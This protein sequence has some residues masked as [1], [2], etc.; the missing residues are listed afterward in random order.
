M[1]RAIAALESQRPV[2]GDTVTELA[3]APLRQ[4]LAQAESTVAPSQ[5]RRAQVTVLFAD[6]VD[7]TA[8]AG[9]LDAEDVLQ[10]F[11]RMLESAAACVRTRGGRV[12]RYTGDGLKAGFGTAG[13][14]EDDAA[15]AVQAGL[16]I[17][18]AAQEHAAW[19]A[20]AHGLQGFAVRVGAHT[21]EV[22]L[23]AGFE[24]DN[25]LTGDTVNL[26]ARMEQAAPPGGLRISAETWAHVRGR[27]DADAQPPLA[28]KGLDQPMS[29]W[30]VRGARGGEVE[31]GIAG[32]A[33]PMIG[34][35]A[36]HARLLDAL[37]AAAAGGGLQA[38]TVV[39]DAGIG[40]TRL[41]REALAEA[42]AGGA[43]VLLARAQPGAEMRPW[44]MLHGLLSAHCGI[45]DSDGAKAARG[46]LLAGLA[47]ELGDDA[48][49]K[50][51]R[52]GQL[53]G[54]DFGDVPA[55]RG[56]DAR[57]LRDL[58]FAALLEWLAGLCRSR[59][60]TA[61]VLV[62]EDLHWADEASLDALAH[63]MEQASALPLLLLAS[64]R[65]RLLERRPG[66]GTG[67]L[68]ALLAL[69]P[70]PEADRSLLA[71][72]LLQRIAHP[73]ERLRALLVQRA[74]GN[75]Y[76]MEELL[77]RLLDDGVIGR[78]GAQWRVDE[79]RLERLR[80]PTTLVGLLQA[81]LDALPAP[82]RH[83][84][85]RASI[86]GHVFWD[87]ALAQIDAAAPQTLDALQ[88]RQWVRERAA[89]AFEGTAERQFDHHLLHQVT[90]DTVLKDER[91]RGH[92]A[93]ARWLAERTAGRAPEFLAITG[94]HAE[95]AGDL[96]LAVDCY[97]R[98]ADEAA[99][100]FANA[101]AID[102]LRK[103]LRLLPADA[104][105]RR[106][107]LLGTLYELGDR[108]GDRPLQHEALALREALLS[109]HPDPVRQATW[110]ADRALLADREG[111]PD[112]AFALATE[113][114]ALAGA[115]GNDDAAA[116]AHGE[117]CWLHGQRLELDDA[118]RHLAAA[119]AA[120]ARVRD[121]H[122]Q[123][124]VSVRVLAGVVE[125]LNN[126]Y[127][128]AR[129]MLEPVLERAEAAQLPRAQLGALNYL[130]SVSTGLQEHARAVQEAAR[131]IALARRLGNVAQTGAALYMQATA[132]N[133]MGE[134]AQALAAAHEAL[135]LLRQ[136]RSRLMEADALNVVGHAHAGRGDP[137]AARAA[138]GQA[139]QV[140]EDMTPGG[141][142]GLSR[143][144]LIA[145]QDL[146][147]GDLPAALA[148][149][150]T[151]LAGLAAGATID[152]INDQTAVHWACQRVLAA[153]GD[154]RAPDHLRGLQAALRAQ[155]LQRTGSEAQAQALIAGTALY[156][157]I[158]A[159]E[160][161]APPGSEPARATA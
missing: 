23:G 5:L 44:G 67:G 28:V 34:R 17:L 56:L 54:L 118:R 125:I 19:A 20:Q 69:T 55:L 79:Q 117:L 15:Q 96:A 95:R 153:A 157:R 124:E 83:G 74:E 10:V 107:G 133:G 39:A 115:A 123:R 40:K 160:P 50:A 99:Q 78:D 81:R 2:L 150:D 89:S 3:L 65:P 7:S 16:D 129:E 120:G 18:A 112:D 97:G 73:P 152:I 46:K 140:Y 32:L 59:V 52:I 30:L 161:T 49:A 43:R 109:E 51:Q 104:A 35:E 145:E 142:M 100:R 88:R 66:W 94:E 127:V 106:H 33:V 158:L 113:A 13:T 60:G 159:A 141:P 87:A 148:A 38:L 70:L 41:L 139:R 93:V 131:F 25:T 86:V 151:V 134:H 132:Y 137:A 146:A 8:L 102:C 80:L 122:P 58:A 143:L 36:E 62:F 72:A 130:C 75:P 85:Q 126:R 42:A 91:R 24:A 105:P 76:Y 111:R 71:D 155:L 116:L 156:R 47:P 26:A 45:V 29:T 37:R 121:T 144:A 22:A 119:L 135:P 61:V 21:G 149:V 82:E 154:A 4:L 48:E 77:R 110:L 11:G 101:L 114:A 63:W 57:A 98:A 53:L 31:R 1:R 68:G 147:Q 92:A 27:F 128:Q 84:V 12:L 9:R 64:A 138:F 14:R 90:Y 136:S 6:I 103:A 108:V